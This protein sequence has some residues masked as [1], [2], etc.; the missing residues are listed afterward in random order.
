MFFFILA[1]SSTFCLFSVFTMICHGDFLF[2]ICL[3][4]V[5]CA[6]CIYMGYVFPEFVQGSFYDLVEDLSVPLT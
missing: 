6:S 5:L 1:G 2:W 3:F 4:G